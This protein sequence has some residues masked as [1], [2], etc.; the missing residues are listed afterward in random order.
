MQKIDLIPFSSS[1]TE[2]E[3][4]LI[5]YLCKQ[6]YLP[7]S[8]LNPINKVENI[9]LYAPMYIFSASYEAEWQASFG[10]NR[11]EHYTEYQ[12][13]YN[14]KGKERIPVARTKIVTDWRPANG[15]ARGHMTLTAYAGEGLSAEAI[16]LMESMS[17]N[18]AVST[19]AQKIDVKVE[20]FSRSEEQ[21]WT[22][23]VNERFEARIDLDIKGRK[24]GDCQRDWS[25]DATSEYSSSNILCPIEGIRIRFDGRIYDFWIDGSNINR[26][27]HKELPKDEKMKR[28]IFIG[29][30]PFAFILGA[31]ALYWDKISSSSTA[32]VVS[33]ILVG[34]AAIGALIRKF[35]IET[36]AREAMLR[37]ASSAFKAVEK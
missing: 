31:V 11:Q 20:P 28:D 37:M 10:F 22:S 9:T 6:K 13:V 35:S 17:V 3:V 4:A 25:W 32:T 30:L 27:R 15:R 33:I 24:Q 2:T 19:D 23:R 12:E 34:V 36:E 7:A 14:S 26:I 16:E 18:N 8:F 5:D 29:F 1:T 21:V